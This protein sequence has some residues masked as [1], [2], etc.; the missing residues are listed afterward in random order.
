M[1]KGHIR[2]DRPDDGMSVTITMLI[3]DKAVG[4]VAYDAATLEDNIHML[5]TARAG[6]TEPVTPELEVGMRLEAVAD[7]RWRTEAYPPAGGSMLALRH[8]GL[9]WVSFLLPPHEARALAASLVAQAD[10]L[11]AN[12]GQEYG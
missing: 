11:E 5:A 7:P 6:M 4:S 9:G 1:G 8:P 3:D 2:W 12:G 10:E